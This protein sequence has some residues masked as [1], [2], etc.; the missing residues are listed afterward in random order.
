MVV[1]KKSAKPS[2]G[3]R[4][5]SGKLP[6]A[7]VLSRGGEDRFQ[8]LIR[9]LTDMIVIVDD[10]GLVSYESPSWAKTI[11]YPEGHFVGQSP[12]PF[13]HPDDL[14]A[15]L[16]DFADTVQNVIDGIP[17]PFRFRRADGAWAYLEALASNMMAHPAIRGIIITVRDVTERIR[18]QEALR[19]SEEKY[20]MLI[21]ASR[22]VIYTVSPD[23]TVQSCSPSVKLALGYKPEE[24]IGKKALKL[25]LIQ[26]DER[27]R[28]AVE[29]NAI[30]AGENAGPT[31]YTMIAKNGSPR[32]AE[33]VSTPLVRNGTVIGF[34]GIARDV[35]EKK[36]IQDELRRSEEKYRSIIETMDSGYYEVDLKGTMTFFNPALMAFLGY[37]K[38]ELTGLQ[39]SAFMDEEESRR[40]FQIFNKVYRTG[41]PS[42]DFYWRFIRKNK[43]KAYSAASAYPVRNDRGTII[44]FSG[45]VRDITVLKDIEVALREREETFRAL[46]ENS[47]DVIMRFD[48]DHRHLYVNP[49]A[50]RQTGI[51]PEAYVGKTHQDLGFPD[52]LVI[53]C[54]EAINEVF[55]TGQP[56]RIEFML[57]DRVWIDWLLVPEFDLQGEVKAVL[58]SA[59]DITGHKKSEDTLR[60][61]ERRLANIIDF[62]PDATFV[63]DKEGRVITWN[64]SMEEMA[65]VKSEEMIGKGDYEHAIP[66]YGEKRPI[67]VDLALTPDEEIERKYLCISR[68]GDR[69]FGEFCMPNLKGRETFLWGTAAPLRDSEGRVV[70]AIESIR[71]ITDRKKAERDLQ[72]AKEEAE[73]INKHLERQ[74]VR[75]NDMAAQA[76]KAN[77]AKSEFLANMSHEIRTP[78]NGVI[79]MSGLLLDT[80][81][82]DEQRRYAE[83]LRNSGE[84]LLA[85]LNDI[86]DFS[87]IEA[88]KL[89]METLDFDLRVL[90]DDFAALMALRA[91]EK[92]IVFICAPE[93]NVPSYLHGDPGRLRQILTNLTGNAVK[94]THEGEIS[95][96]ASLVSETDAEAVL[97]FSIKDTG[98]GIPAGKQ[99]ILFQKFTQADASTT[100]Q[101]GGTGLGL[102]ISK[103]LAERMGGEIGIVSEE[104]LGSEFWFTARLGKQTERE[105]KIMPPADIRGMHVLVV[106]DNAINRKVLMTQCTV[107]GL[108]PEETPYGPEAL[109]ALYRTRDSGDP[110]RAA[111]LDIPMPD[112][113]GTWLA[114]AIKADESLKETR[115]VLLTSIGQRGDANKMKEIG[116]SAYLT[117]P[118]R[119]SELF[120]CLS[121][122]LSGQAEGQAAQPIITRHMIR[123]LHR[124]A[125]CILLAE[126]N[127]T[128]Q[129]VAVSILKKLGLRADT[130]ANGAEAVKALE[131]LPYDLVLMDVQMPEMDG[132]E[133]TRAIRNPQSAVRNHRIPIIAMTAHAMQ[134]DRERCLE[135]GMNDYI[136][137]P[138]DPRALAEAL[139]K[140]LPKE[141]ATITDQ[142]PEVS[143]TAS[144][145]AQEPEAPVFDKAGMMARMMDDE[146]LARAV[147]EAF[148]G[149]VPKQIAALRGYLDAG[150]AA[151]A[152]RQTHT[153]KGASANLG[154]EALRAV[155]FEMEK[156]AKAGHLEY[157]KAHLPELENQFIR[158]K[159][160]MEQHCNR[161]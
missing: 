88:G 144:V 127:I 93:P 131:T 17:T 81:L 8:A 50:G 62:L 19:E 13:I 26:P 159:Q 160:A 82:S 79:G 101:Y 16:K 129:M 64:R 154:G 56:H 141:K 69:I 15:A 68:E 102:A 85:L 43:E 70:G 112:L 80:Q 32:I 123:E 2:Q 37:E 76:A 40:V 74:T 86:L 120:G 89:E 42:G 58:A 134:G 147:I 98:I 57:S 12:F 94:F 110:F 155:A 106:N 28:M 23:L 9:N 73:K 27:D 87:K 92:G 41:M 7:K 114:R 46:A 139:E 29:I 33:I 140:W 51:P 149:D 54:D 78:M 44:G 4:G 138:V 77:A 108:R 151:S 10:K 30:L 1:E 96:R 142:A 117:K 25:N 31:I 143:E 161:R 119:Q 150:E 36:K 121:S 71:D 95:V 97:R 107:W 153:I 105:N 116:F 148:L 60:E 99:N 66:F 126:D 52:D 113:D 125:I 55:G 39:Y 34:T 75:A 146:E 132:L 157:V 124:S 115:L 100:R 91:Q 118:V 53:T 104:G 61:S 6:P 47:P 136:I 65:G 11:G 122:V 152:V 84:S 103:Q 83:I 109:Q 59:R 135:A 128:N 24:L 90:L 137:K 145:S 35:T 38:A 5:A 133:A 156:A 18:A 130:V 3:E 158:L 22:D 48:R 111:I 49:A 67:L 20:R 21:N 14:P 72:A 45:T 63:V